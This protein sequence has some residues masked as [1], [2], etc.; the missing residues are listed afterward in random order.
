MRERGTLQVMEIL[1]PWPPSGGGGAI[2]EYGRTDP[3]DIYSATLQSYSI[4]G[5]DVHLKVAEASQYYSYIVR[6]GDPK[7]KD[8]IEAVFSSSIGVS[9]RDI[10]EVVLK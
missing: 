9:V 1:I 10:G 8:R 7:Y 4:D 2:N 3:K 5:L 6:I